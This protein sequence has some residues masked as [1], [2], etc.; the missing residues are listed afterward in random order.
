MLNLP[1]NEKSLWRE[2]YP[3]S[4][5]YPELAKNISVDA[6]VIGAGIT[7]L[8]SA[9]LLKASGLSVA[10]I[11]K[12]TVGGGT[13]ARTT[14]KVTSQHNLIY[15]DLKQ[16]LGTDVARAYGQGNHAA[17]EQ[18]G[19]IVRKLK[20]DCGWQRD[21][22][23]VFTTK[24]EEVDKFRR[25]ASVA[26]SLGL[27]ASFEKDSP[28]PFNIKAAVKFA[29][30]GKIHSQKYL[31][32]LATAVDGDGS[33]VFEGTTAKR[34]HDGEPAVVK[35]EKGSIRARDIIVATRVPTFPLVA[36]A[37]YGLLEYPTESFA[38]AGPAATDLK[39]MYISPDDGHHSILP[40]K[41]D[42]QKVLVLVGAGGNIPGI[43]IS[44]KR[45]QQKLADYGAKWFR[46]E[47]V[48]N[49]WS[50]MDYMAYDG[51]PLIGKVYPW[52]KHLYAGTAYRKWGLTN[53]T[54]AAMVLHDLVVGKKNEYAA[55]FRSTRLSPVAS[56]PRAVV[57]QI[58]G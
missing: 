54:M 49:R 9:Y 4:A 34:I 12:S 45:R 2:S 24:P 53:G 15:H 28:L 30:Q 41:I 11:E 35:T 52:S 44:K 47:R 5:I 57:K 19:N 31:L 55:V 16:R 42:G 18:V 26:K 58:F 25:E 40:T 1:D 10:V 46:L 8:T 37:G 51:V 17:L 29:N 27:P 32:G 48:T 20:I 36:R 13:T 22:N 33:Y 7:G 14:G 50:D 39:G 38:V 43:R 21:D 6:I 23:Y 56:I 3:A